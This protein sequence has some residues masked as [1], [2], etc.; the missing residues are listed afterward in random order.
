[1]ITVTFA[2][3]LSSNWDE[4]QDQLQDLIGGFDHFTTTTATELSLVTDT[5]AHLTL[6]GTFNNAN[7]DTRMESTATGFTATTAG[8][9]PIID[10]SGL[11]G[12]TV[13]AIVEDED[14][15]S[16]LADAAGGVSMDG[17]EGNDDLQGD[18]GNDDLNGGDGDD[19]L[20]GGDGD[21]DLQGDD[22]DDDLSGGRGDDDLQGGIGVDTLSGGAG[23]DTLAGGAGR[24][25]GQGGADDD[26]LSGGGGGDDLNGGG[27]VDVVRGQAGGDDLRGGGGSDRLSGGTGDDVVH[28]DN[29]RDAASG[30]SGADQFVLDTD[31]GVDRI[32]DFSTGEDQL[33]LD[34]TALAALG[35]GALS[36]EQFVSAGTVGDGNDYLVYDQGAGILYYDATGNAGTDHA[37]LHLGHGTA[38][39][40]SDILV[41]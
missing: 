33:A 22:G 11:S 27:G 19:D 12:V 38:L 24:Y 3:S 40:A 36:S 17:D 14:Y 4:L 31:R 16:L 25:D 37:I 21:D 2:G 13:G 10:V 23:L 15:S 30:G 8:G 18:D 9:D 20:Q 5:G 7:D 35:L 32:K 6:H 26:S 39:A 28:L 29:G 1:M 41:I 34:H